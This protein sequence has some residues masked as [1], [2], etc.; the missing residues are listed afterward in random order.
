[1]TEH[2]DNLRRI[3]KG[4]YHVCYHNG[5]HGDWRVENKD[6]DLYLPEIAHLLIETKTI[7]HEDIA[8]KNFPG[9]YEGIRYDECDI[10]YPGIVCKDAP[11]PYGKKYR[12]IDGSHRMAKMTDMKVTKSC[13]YII[14]YAILKQ[15]ITF[16][17]LFK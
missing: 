15:F 5:E 4:G 12:M 1:M 10:S 13:Y 2:V 8:W 6:A 3:L 9:K 14:E 7:D 11:N 17:R 16:R